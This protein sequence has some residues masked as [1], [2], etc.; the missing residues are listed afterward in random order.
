MSAAGVGLGTSLSVLQYRSKYGYVRQ[1]I[2]A[3][4]DRAGS[5]GKWV[6]K[7]GDGRS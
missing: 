2:A 7:V 3:S 5:A 4:E 6:N 1:N